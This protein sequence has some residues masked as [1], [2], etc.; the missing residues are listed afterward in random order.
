MSAS[1]APEIGGLKLK[2]RHPNASVRTA[3]AL[4]ALHY[5]S[6]I[7]PLRNRVAFTTS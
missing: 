5:S 3:L 7:A 6:A 4:M 2:Q 1:V